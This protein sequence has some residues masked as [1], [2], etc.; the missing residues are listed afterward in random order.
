MASF[1]RLPPEL[2]HDIFLLAFRSNNKEGRNLIFVAKR[3]FDWLIPHIFN[4][5]RLD[6]ARPLP[7]KFNESV[8]KRHGK[9]TRHLFIEAGYGRYLNLFPNVID[10]AFWAD[11]SGQAYISSLLQLPLTRISITPSP[12]LF[13]IFSKVTHLDLL[14]HFSLFDA[15]SFA[16]IVQP[17]VYLPNLTHLCVLPEMSAELVELFL[18]RTRCPALKVMIFWGPSEGELAELDED[19]WSEYKGNDSRIVRV[20][21]NPRRDWELGARGGVDMWIF[22]DGIMASRDKLDL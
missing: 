16:S 15:D 1:P 19:D 21:C 20:K 10:L 5:V 12:S 14:T 3:V 11:C 22:V 18:D 17:L 8:Y 9:H 2:E 6:K 4:I 7:T 13:Q